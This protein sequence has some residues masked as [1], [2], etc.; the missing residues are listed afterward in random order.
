MHAYSSHHYKK[1]YNKVSIIRTL[2]IRTLYNS[3]VSLCRY[4]VFIRQFFIIRTFTNPNN[5]LRPLTDPISEES[6]LYWKHIFCSRSS[7]RS[8]LNCLILF[9]KIRQNMPYWKHIFCIRSSWRRKLYYLW[10]FSLLQNIKIISN[11]EVIGLPVY[12]ISQNFRKN[13][14][15]LKSAVLR[16]PHTFRRDMVAKNFT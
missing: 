6:S 7:W 9:R 5:Y 11:V 8:N 1:S 10:F 4:K 16:V 3:I 2:T 13:P 12:W 15:F 14:L